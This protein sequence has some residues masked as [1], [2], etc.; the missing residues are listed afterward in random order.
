MSFSRK[1]ILRRTQTWVFLMLAGAAAFSSLLAWATPEQPGHK[2]LLTGSQISPQVVSALE[3]ACQNCHSGNTSWPWYSN[4]PPV[5]WK[6]H[7]DVAR[8]RQFMDFS[9]WGEYTDLQKRG[10][11]TSIA[12]AVETRAMPPRGYLVLHPEARLSEAD[13][14]ALENW[15]RMRAH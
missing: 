14:S 3:R 2:P 11:R 8:A 6:V 13:R 7:G 10:F 1:L 4:I 15:A 5:S 12:T 9:K